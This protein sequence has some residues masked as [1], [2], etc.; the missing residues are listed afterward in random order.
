MAGNT[1]DDFIST[2]SGVQ[3]LHY[4]QNPKEK[5][6]RCGLIPTETAVAV[7]L[8]DKRLYYSTE[9]LKISSVGEEHFERLVNKIAQSQKCSDMVYYAYQALANE[10]VSTDYHAQLVGAIVDS[11]SGFYAY[12]ALANERVSTDF[13]SDLVS[14]I[15]RSNSKYYATQALKLER[16]QDKSL[17]AKLEAI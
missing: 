12:E 16:L 6:Y 15:I 11:S 5:Y 7:I 14:T 17:I 8:K 10:K 4:L 13:D 9:A 2:Q 1:L 3:G